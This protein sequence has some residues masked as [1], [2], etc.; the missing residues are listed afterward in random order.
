MS[1]CMLLQIELILQEESKMNR[2]NDCNEDAV[3]PGYE[4]WTVKITSWNGPH[5]NVKLLVVR[6]D[7]HGQRNKSKQWQ[8]DKLFTFPMSHLVKWS[9][10][11]D[12]SY[13]PAS[14]FLSMPELLPPSS[15]STETDMCNGHNQ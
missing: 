8:D 13:I 5:M 10:S 4:R 14:F 7:S 1:L 15:A 11:H 2:Q 9:K 12:D 3:S 6:W